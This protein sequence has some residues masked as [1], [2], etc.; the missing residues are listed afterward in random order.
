M[1]RAHNRTTT[2]TQHTHASRS[3]LTERAAAHWC[4]E[5]QNDCPSTR[6]HTD[7]RLSHTDHRLSQT[8]PRSIRRD[9]SLISTSP[10]TV[11]CRRLRGTECASI[12]IGASRTCTHHTLQQRHGRR[13]YARMG[14]QQCA[15]H[16][17]HTGVVC[18]GPDTQHQ[19]ASLRLRPTRAPAG[20]LE[21]LAQ[22]APARGRGVLGWQWQDAP[23]L[24]P[25]PFRPH[26]SRAS[27]LGYAL[28]CANPNK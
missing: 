7:Y 18:C 25:L 24:H 27:G 2:H 22:R 3:G 12:S 21:A 9:G 23:S 4:G 28:P 11:H 6:D 13:S 17:P 19:E 1:I 16:R 26:L 20:R 10:V 14:R 8:D 5:P 15:H